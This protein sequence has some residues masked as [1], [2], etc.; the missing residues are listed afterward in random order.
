MKQILKELYHKKRRDYAVW[1]YL[2]LFA[3]DKNSIEFSHSDLCSRF[4]LPLSSLHRIL[5]IYPEMWNEEKVYV[6][7]EKIR[8]K[9]FKV[10]FYPKGKKIIST[11]LAVNTL[12][13]ELFNWLKTDYYPRIN[14]DYTDIARHKRFVGLI[15]EKLEKALKSRKREV[16]NE[17]IKEIFQQFFNQIDSWWIN[18]GIVSLTVINKNFTQILNKQIQSN[19]NGGKKRDSYTKAAEE[20]GDIDFSKLTEK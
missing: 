5:N 10:T 3:D 4:S 20:S 8:Y 15:R 1:N 12:D 6:K 17:I 13:N 2:W 19:G 14:Y 16:N 9:Q 18:N 7:Y 11:D